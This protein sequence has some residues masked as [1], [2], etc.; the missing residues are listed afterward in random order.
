MNNSLSAFDPC[1]TVVSTQTLLAALDRDDHAP[2]RREFPNTTHSREM[3][4]I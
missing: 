2:S 3:E 1:G 4:M